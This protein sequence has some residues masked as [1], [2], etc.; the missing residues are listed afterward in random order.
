[1]KHLRVFFFALLLLASPL[2]QGNITVSS[3][4]F[5]DPDPDLHALAKRILFCS[6]TLSL[7]F[8]SY[9][10]FLCRLSILFIVSMDW[11]EI[12]LIW[13][14]GDFVDIWMVMLARILLC[15]CYSSSLLIYWL[16]SC[17]FLYVLIC[18]WKWNLTWCFALLIKKSIF[19]ML[20]GDR[21]SSCNIFMLDNNTEVLLE[22]YWNEFLLFFGF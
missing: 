17:F 4:H 8:F 21:I 18:F 11:I 9:L 22:L 20:I 6:W 13:L 12:D 7:F 19:Q 15:L 2:L 16:T 10:K 3:S 1:M 14:F 5:L